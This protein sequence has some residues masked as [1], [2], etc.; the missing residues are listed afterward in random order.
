MRNPHDANRR[1]WDEVTPI[2]RA[3]AFYNVEA[4]L[5]G[6]CTVGPIE[7]DALS[8]LLRKNLLHLQCH[9]GLDTLSLLR[10]GASRVTG[11]D[12]SGAAVREAQGLAERLK[13]D[14]W[15]EF[16]EAD[17]LDLDLKSRFER[18][19]TSHGAIN[20]LSDLEAWGRVVARHLAQDGVFY[21]MEA[22]P[23]GLAMDLETSGRLYQ[24]FDY[25]HKDEPLAL[26]GVPDYAVPDY[27]PKEPGIGWNWTVADVMAAL[28]GAGLQVFEFREYPFAAW[29]ALPGM[30]ADPRGYYWHR[31]PGAGP[32]LPLL[33]SLKA[34]HP[35]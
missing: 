12:L 15:A 32:D 31:A 1:H 29:E 9:F 34:R 5:G 28:E 14:A 2:H 19:F 3:S 22:H 26:D 24:R 16:I 7:R 25:F 8:P 4:F 18:I 13:L 11:V 35:A 20:W 33:F 30:V 17:V 27:L 6:H 21:M 10:L 23:F